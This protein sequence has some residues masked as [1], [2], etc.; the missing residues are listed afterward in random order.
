MN[1]KGDRHDGEQRA[2]VPKDKSHISSRHPKNVKRKITARPKTKNSVKK[3]NTEKK[4]RKKVKNTET[5]SSNLIKSVLYIMV[6]M[7]AAVILSYVGITAG[8][9]IFA[10]VKEDVSFSVTVE[11]SITV[12]ELGNILEE[13]GVIKYPSV[14][15][16]YANLRKKTPAIEAGVYEV[17]SNMSYDQLIAR[18]SN[19]NNK[20]RTTVVVTIPEGYT[21][22]QIV[23]LLVNKHSL[24]SKEELINAIQ[25]YEFDYWFVERLNS[26]SLKQGRKYRLEGYL[27]PDTYYYYSDSSAVTII[28]KMLS[29]FDKKIKEIF[30]DDKKVPGDNYIEKTDYL[31]E[32]YNMSFDEMI[33]LASMI[34]SESKYDTEFGNISSVFHNRLSNP[35]VTNGKLESDATIQYF[36]EKHT[37]KLNNEHLQI[38]NPYN[39]YIY[40]GLPPG[41]ISNP[42]QTAI[43]YALYPSKTSYYFFVAGND[44]YS[45]FA[46]T[47]NEHNKNIAKVN[48]EKNQG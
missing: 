35:S 41:S 40:Q 5:F 6:I 39:T 26:S 36:L 7:L 31:C 33:I 19:L 47:L 23:D 8:N 16:L 17:N 12:K 15:K 25:N 13:K 37:E 20:E 48:S 28:K 18:F 29:N 43:I 24:S 22:D 11:E 30:K 32:K 42:A 4:G 2:L 34:Q 46:K 1:N 10:L 27:Y 3:Y 38:D 44:G 9:D 45:L 14:F 21:I